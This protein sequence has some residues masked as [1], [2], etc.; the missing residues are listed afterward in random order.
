MHIQQGYIRSSDKGVVRIRVID[1]QAFLTIES[2][3]KGISRDEFEYEIP[4]ADGEQMLRTMCG[5]ILRKKRYLMDLP[6]GLVLELDVFTQIDLIIAE[7]ELP[8][9]DA[10]FSGPDWL[11]L[12]VSKDPRYSNNNIAQSL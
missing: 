8:S 6:C 9:E 4:K 7:I 2:K 12:D 11:G 5:P 10:L 3:A 1:N